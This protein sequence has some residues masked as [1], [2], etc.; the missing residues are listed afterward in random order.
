MREV[1]FSCG[2]FCALNIDFQRYSMRKINLKKGADLK[3]KGEVT[4][5]TP[6][7]VKV[8]KIAVCPD[9]FPGFQPK[10]SV[11]PGDTVSVGQAVMFDKNHPEVKL[12]SPVNGTV[13]EVVRGERRK[14][15]RVVIDVAADATAI[16][17]PL[18]VKSAL[19]DD[20]TLKLLLQNSGLWSFMRQRPYDIVPDVDKT[21]RDIFV[22]TFDS[23]PLAVSILKYVD[24]KYVEAGIKA[25]KRL[26]PGNVFIGVQKGGPQHIDGGECVMFK[27]PHP[28]GNAGVQA[29]AIAPVNKGETIWCLDIITVNRIGRLLLTGELDTLTAVAVTGPEVKKPC[30]VTTIEGAAIAPVI[31][32][33]LV[34][35]GCH[36]RMVSGNVLTGVKESIDGFLHFPY[37]Q[38]TVISEGDDV[39]EFMGWAAI[40]ASKMSQ[41]PTFLSHLFPGKRFSPDARLHGGKRAM[42]LSGQYDKVFPMDILPEYLIKAIIAKDIDKMEQLGI[43][44]VAP[45]DF[46]LCEYVDASKIEVQKIVREGLDYMRKELE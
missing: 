7:F 41:S 16:E 4:D 27:G 13:D 21:P 42:I 37:R 30:I 28:S 14:L 6:Q 10:V 25:L 36:L 15:L 1:K 18:D 8:G 29:A 33:N 2:I 22:T 3:L 32:N 31:E 40:G 11:K 20:T 38:I 17:K 34:N 35:S 19:T 43:Y 23:A 26:T 45:E 46:A 12:V 5:F 9:D 44:E 39:D 24:S